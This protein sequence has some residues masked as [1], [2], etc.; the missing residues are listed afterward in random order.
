MVWSVEYPVRSPDL[1]HLKFNFWRYLK[2]RGC[3]NN[4]QTNT[5]MKEAVD[6]EI[7]NTGSEVTKVV[8]DSIKKRVENPGLSNF[9]W[10]PFL[11]IILYKSVFFNFDFCR[12]FLLN[13]GLSF[14]KKLKKNCQH[15]LMR[16]ASNEINVRLRIMP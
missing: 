5:E 2:E 7:T 16:V 1:S 9:T 11:L 15:S 12:T 14:S 10:V 8:T 13:Q 6:E 4:P 3:Q